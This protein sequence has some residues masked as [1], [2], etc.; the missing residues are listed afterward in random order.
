MRKE[1]TSLLTFLLITRPLLTTTITTPSPETETHSFTKNKELVIPIPKDSD[2]TFHNIPF[3]VFHL[4]TE[5]ESRARCATRVGDYILDLSILEKK[6]I[7][8][9]KMFQKINYVFNKPRL[10]NFMNLSPDYWKHVRLTIQKEIVNNTS[11]ISKEIQNLLNE[12]KSSYPKHRVIYHKREVKMIIPGEVGDYTDFYSSYNHAFNMGSLFR[13]PKNAVKENWLYLPVGYHGRSSSVVVSGTNIR[14]P[15][16][17]IRGKNGLPKFGLSNKLDFE[18]EMGFF[19]GNKGNKLGDV[20][21]VNEADE[22]IFG[23]VLMNDWSARD[24]QGWEYVPLG[25]FTG[26]NLGTVISPWV[27]TL[28]ALKPFK[29]KLPEPKI[30]FMSYLDDKD[31]SSYDINLQVYFNFD[32]DEKSSLKLVSE[33]NYK[34]MY[35]TM[36]QQLAHHSVT[37]CNMRTGDLLGS[38]SFMY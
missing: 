23:L 34:Y 26:K 2:F 16:G 35:W 27:V 20:I 5:S 28:E 36:K 18:L 1:L 12:K 13:D 11:E 7:F 37:G 32:K 9:T 8:R 19:V 21:D 29:V 14:R 10:N 6:G 4:K 22:H 33:S 38:G 15:R 31:Y 3:G 30:P 24:I 17:Q 25:P